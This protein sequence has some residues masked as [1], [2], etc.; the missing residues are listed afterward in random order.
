MCG[1]YKFSENLINW[2]KDK[3]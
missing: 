3:N 1:G 2:K